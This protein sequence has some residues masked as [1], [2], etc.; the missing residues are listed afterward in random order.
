MFVADVA[1]ML[2]Y[3][4]CLLLCSYVLDRNHR[5]GGAGEAL[6][7]WLIIFQLATQPHGM[8]RTQRVVLAGE[9]QRHS[10]KRGPIH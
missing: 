6:Q 1:V 2:P 10:G 3:F 8:D 7:G 4:V 9:V 5:K